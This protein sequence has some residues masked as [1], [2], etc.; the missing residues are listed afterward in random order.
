[1][2]IVVVFKITNGAKNNPWKLG[3]HCYVRKIINDTSNQREFFF[4]IVIPYLANLNRIAFWQ[5]RHFSIRLFRYIA[6]I[7]HKPIKIWKI[8]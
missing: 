4:Q 1:M 5:K 2:I 3:V 8:T 6:E 7:Q